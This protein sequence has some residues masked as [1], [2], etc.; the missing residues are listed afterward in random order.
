MKTVTIK[1]LNLVEVPEGEYE[2]IKAFQM[3][4]FTINFYGK[5]MVFELDTKITSE[6]QFVIGGNGF[7]Q[8]GYKI[9]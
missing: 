4:E 2:D 9:N 7:I 6:G 8:D 3:V 1:K 5:E